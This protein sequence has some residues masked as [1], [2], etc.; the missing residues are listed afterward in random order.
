[1]LV[2]LC[3][4]HLTICPIFYVHFETLHSD[5]NTIRYHTMRDQYIL[6]YLECYELDIQMEFFHAEEKVGEQ[7]NYL[8][9]NDIT[10][11]NPIND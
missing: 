6:K 4:Q 11:N 10:Y 1:M 2:L 9:H 3:V 7:L 5:H 8:V